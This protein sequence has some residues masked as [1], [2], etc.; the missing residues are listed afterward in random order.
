MQRHGHVREEVAPRVRLVGA[1]PP[2]LR[3][4]VDHD[5]RS[6]ILERPPHVGLPG[7]VVVTSPGHEQLGDAPRAQ[8]FGHG[9]AEETRASGEHDPVGGEVDLFLV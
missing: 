2:D 8:A 6:R 9:V 5:G 7:E 1:D 4:E 3:R